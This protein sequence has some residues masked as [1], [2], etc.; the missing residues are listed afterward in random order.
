MNAMSNATKLGEK[1]AKL[2]FTKEDGKQYSAVTVQ[3]QCWVMM[4]MISADSPQ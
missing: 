4:M 2:M 3:R 1:F